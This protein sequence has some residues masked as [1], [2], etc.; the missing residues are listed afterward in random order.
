MTIYSRSSK[1][2]FL[3]WYFLPFLFFLC[4]LPVYITYYHWHFISMATFC[5]PFCPSSRLEVLLVFP[6]H[7]CKILLSLPRSFKAYRDTMCVVHSA[8]S[9]HLFQSARPTQGNCVCFLCSLNSIQSFSNLQETPVTKFAEPNVKYKYKSPC[10]NIIK[11]FKMTAAQLSQELIPLSMLSYATT[12]LKPWSQSY[13]QGWLGGFKCCYSCRQGESSFQINTVD[14]AGTLSQMMFPVS[15][16]HSSGCPAFRR[17]SAASCAFPHKGFWTR[18][19]TIPCTVLNS[20]T[21][22]LISSYT[23]VC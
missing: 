11:I 18:N 8:K 14:S 19:W 5:P 9:Q 15:L 16:L 21:S 7:F 4:I 12:Y 23:Y 1:S 6:Q 17:G 2:F 3:P 10:S 22:L 20:I 13:Q